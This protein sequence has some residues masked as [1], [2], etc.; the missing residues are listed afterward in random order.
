MGP[1]EDW[2]KF[3]LKELKMLESD[4]IVP[5]T[6]KGPTEQLMPPKKNVILQNTLRVQ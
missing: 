2:F 4:F 6:S 5:K 1:S 3:N